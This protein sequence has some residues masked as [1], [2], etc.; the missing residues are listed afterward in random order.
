MFKFS[1]SLITKAR[2]KDV[3]NTVNAPTWCL[4]A[5]NGLYPSLYLSLVIQMLGHGDGSLV[6]TIQSKTAIAALDTWDSFPFRYEYGSFYLDSSLKKELR[7]TCQRHG[8]SAATDNIK[9]GECGM[10]FSPNLLLH[11]AWVVLLGWEEMSVW[12]P[13]RSTW[14]VSAATPR[15]SRPFCCFSKAI[16]VDVLSG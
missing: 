6:Q 9:C 13:G 7:Q 3:K 5:K 11:H 8:C 4:W 1:L 2:H 14:I 15:R 16:I 10:G 12:S